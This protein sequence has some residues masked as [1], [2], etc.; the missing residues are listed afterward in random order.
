MASVQRFGFL[1]KDWH[2]T[3]FY[4]EKMGIYP[5]E[6]QWHNN[7]YKRVLDLFLIIL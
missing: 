4:L 2:R 1:S 7:C 3:F 6:F 5:I